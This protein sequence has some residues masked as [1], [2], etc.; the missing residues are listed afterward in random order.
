M[1]EIVLFPAQPSTPASSPCTQQASCGEESVGWEEC[2]VLEVRS[3]RFQ[4]I[5]L[6]HMTM[7]SFAGLSLL[8]KTLC[9]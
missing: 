4:F 9:L 1:K 8:Y 6:G 3:Y 5:I 2:C 7:R